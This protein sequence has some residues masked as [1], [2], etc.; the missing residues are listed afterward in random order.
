MK[1]CSKALW[2][3]LSRS[4]PLQVHWGQ[5]LNSYKLVLYSYVSSLADSCVCASVSWGS[6]RSTPWTGPTYSPRTT[7]LPYPAAETV[8]VIRS[9]FNIT[10][11]FL[12]RSF[13]YI[14]ELQFEDYGWAPC[15]GQS[16]F[17][18][19]W[20]SKKLYSNQP[21]HLD[22][23]LQIFTLA[24]KPFLCNYFLGLNV[25]YSFVIIFL[26]CEKWTG[27]WLLLDPTTSLSL[28]VISA[29]C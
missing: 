15:L 7:P 29:F 5:I 23:D 16:L 8:L 20:C 10:S 24:I 26:V 19:S 18:C 2:K 17:T 4:V 11:T 28:M 1:S 3:P 22:F 21:N 25:L 14:F 13:I 12:V 9:F 6:S 27:L